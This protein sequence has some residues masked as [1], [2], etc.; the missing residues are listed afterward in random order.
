[1]CTSDLTGKR[2]CQPNHCISRSRRNKTKLSRFWLDRLVD[3]LQRQK[4]ERV[5]PDLPAANDHGVQQQ[6]V[7]KVV[8]QLAIHFKPV[9]W[10]E[11]RTSYISW[12]V[13]L[14]VN[15][16]VIQFAVGAFRQ[17]GVVIL[18]LAFGGQHTPSHHLNDLNTAK[19]TR[20]VFIL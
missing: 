18:H 17:A 2:Y 12:F 15:H 3:Q 9:K 7:T 4:G 20:D 14:L 13:F 5:P 16:D 10:Q 19:N 1:M 6:S 8:W 11:N